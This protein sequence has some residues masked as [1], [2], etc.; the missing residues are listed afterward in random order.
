MDTVARFVTRR[1][2]EVLWEAWDQAAA[3]AGKMNS[4][5]RY[6]VLFPV[7]GVDDGEILRSSLVKAR[8]LRALL[9]ELYSESES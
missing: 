3:K 4:E 1:G 5:G 2:A 7:G 6:W 8:V 9:P